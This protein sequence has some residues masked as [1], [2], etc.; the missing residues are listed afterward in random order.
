MALD[1]A[2]ATSKIPSQV[3]RQKAPRP[4]AASQGVKVMGSEGSEIPRASSP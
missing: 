1:D 3:E 4:I 2:R